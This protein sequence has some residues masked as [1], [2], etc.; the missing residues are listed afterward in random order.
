MPPITRL[1]W[2]F[3]NPDEHRPR[4]LVRIALQI[5]LTVLLLL[6]LGL[7]VLGPLWG[8]LRTGGLSQELVDLVATMLGTT[9]GSGL[10]VV[11]AVWLATRFLDRR[12]FADLGLHLDT[13][14]W[15]DFAFGLA[16]GILLMTGIFLAEW[17]AGWVVVVGYIR[18]PAG[19]PFAVAIWGP[20]VFFLAVGFYEELLARG[21]WLRNLA[22]GLS[23]PGLGPSGGLLLA[24]ALT[25]G[26]FGALHMGNPNATWTST[27]NLVLAGLLLGLPVILTGELAISIGLHITWN[28]FQGNVYGFPVS[29]LSANQV[30]FLA[31]EQR[32]PELWTGGAFGP[33]A[34]LIG[35]GAMGVGVLLILAWLRWTRGSLALH[36]EW[37]RYVPAPASQAE[38]LLSGESSAP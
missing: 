24:Y 23:L 17:L 12:P 18:S 3:W 1:H 34:G 32:G 28:F 5:A 22:E 29:G 26:I 10:S 6:V 36:T 2:L 21:Y 38:R 4:A 37:A 30:T 20:V 33:E 16:L 14:W 9:L 19:I 15:R 7:L 35:I 31:I 11:L 27:A 13:T 8:A 25:S